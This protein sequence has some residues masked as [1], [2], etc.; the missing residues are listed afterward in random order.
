[1]PRLANPALRRFIAVAAPAAVVA[2]VL[3][4][5]SAA[6]TPTQLA[7]RP[8]VPK[9]AWTACDDGFEC[10]TATVPLDYSKPRGRTISIA[11]TRLPATDRAHRIGS[12]FV[13]PG[14]PGGSGVNF[15]Q[16]AGREVYSAQLRARFDIVGFDPRFIGASRPL[17][18]CASDDETEE[19]LGDLPDFPITRAQ[20]HRV[21]RANQ[22]YTALCAKRSPFLAYA[23]TA[24]VARDLNLLRQAVGDRK[25]N[26]VGYSYGSILGQTYAA[27]FPSKVRALTIDGVI[28]AQE[29][30]TG[31]PRE[32]RRVPFTTR[33]DSAIGAYA[34][35][36]QF[37]ALCDQIGASG[38]AFANDGQAREKF[39]RLA[40]RLKTEPYTLPDGTVLDYPLLVGATLGV[41]YDPLS[42]QDFA[43]E[44]EAVYQ[45][46]FGTQLRSTAADQGAM[47]LIER[48]SA[49][50]WTAAGISPDAV[51]SADSAD[52]ARPI[53]SGFAAF[54][55]VAC[56][57]SI[58]PRSER[59]WAAAGAAQDRV[60]PY[61]G[62]AWTWAGE[63]CASW[64]LPGKGRYLGPYN[65]ATSSPVLVIGNIYDPATP[66]SGAQA[67]AA[68]IPRA[69]LLT[70]NGYGH[71][72]LATPSACANAAFDA[73]TI[74]GRVP[75][76]G[77]VCEQ[78]VAPFRG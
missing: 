19:L 36:Q 10:A 75:A 12:L 76:R 15:V 18:T 25:L 49:P 11:L 68:A 77:A 63:P 48:A 9:L 23:S 60:A 31:S 26:Y 50:R 44:L 17:A 32:S 24:N 14:G 55:A 58:N 46:V 43:D 35:F 57:D 16:A 59:A 13:N 21:H 8:A 52:E 62:R 78:D 40:A 73:Y 22:R 66:Y 30:S 38:C 64:Q 39:D 5:G 56:G 51:D 69:R 71:T 42:W 53:D 70:V 6:A 34:T 33:I 1:M 74:S 54:L 20:E 4:A 67:A 61:F 47:A 27:L 2:G 41:L 7:A 45:A 28:D 65:K 37:T 29:W 3:G 72:S